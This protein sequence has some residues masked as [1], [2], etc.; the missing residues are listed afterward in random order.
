[1]GNVTDG[2]KSAFRDFVTD[3]VPASGANKPFKSEAR[4]LGAI[5]ESAL[6]TI[7]LGSVD[8]TKTTR[9]LLNADLAHAADSVGLVY[10]DS[11]D[12]NN[13][14]Y[15]KVG[16]TGSGSWTL[17]TVLH[18]AIGG[19]ATSQVAA[20]VDAQVDPLV[21]AAADSATA[22]ASS[23]TAAGGSAT[24]AAASEAAAAASAATVAGSR[25]ASL[26]SAVDAAKGEAALKALFSFEGT[27]TFSSGSNVATW[28]DT[29]P[30]ALVASLYSTLFSGANPRPVYASDGISF[31][32]E[33]GLTVSSG[34]IAQTINAAIFLDVD[35]TAQSRTSY[36][37][38]AALVAGGAARTQGD[39]GIVTGGPLTAFTPDPPFAID[40]N[41]ADT[42][43]KRGYYRRGWTGVNTSGG[44][45]NTTMTGFP[46]FSLKGA[47]PATQL[48]DLYVNRFGQLELN[49]YNGGAQNYQATTRGWPVFSG[50]HLVSIH[51][52]RST[53]WLYVD[54]R[55]AGAAWIGAE[56]CTTF[57]TT[58]FNGTSRQNNALTPVNGLAHKAR[59]RGAIENASFAEFQGVHD[60]LA[61]Y[62]DSPKLDNPLYYNIIC[63]L[64]Q[65][66]G[67]ASTDVSA[68]P[69][70]I[71][72]WNGT[73]IP[74]NTIGSGHA[75]ESAKISV[76]SL[77]GK[78][79]ATASGYAA[80]SH[81][82]PM[83]LITNSAG[84]KSTGQ[85]YYQPNG[86]GIEIGLFRYIL[87]DP[88]TPDA[89][90]GYAAACQ[91][92]APVEYLQTRSQPTIPYRSLRGTATTSMTFP[93]Q[94]FP[95]A[96]ASSNLDF[97]LAQIAWQ[98]DHARARGQIPR[99]VALIPDSA[100]IGN[101]V[102]GTTSW[103]TNT[104]NFYDAF[105][106]HCKRLTDQ[107]TD[108]MMLVQAHS[109]SSDGTQMQG[110]NNTPYA[111]QQCLDV[112]AAR[113]SRGIYYIG[114]SYHHSPKGHQPRIMYRAHGEETGVP[115]CAVFNRGVD[116]Q[117]LRVIAVINAS[118]SRK[119]VFNKSVAL[120]ETFGKAVTGWLRQNTYITGGILNPSLTVTG[121]ATVTTTNVANDTI[122]IPVSGTPTTGDAWSVG[123]L[124][125]IYTNIRHVTGLTGNF[126]SLDFA[127]TPDG[128][129]NIVFAESA[130]NNVLDEWA[131]PQN[132]LLTFV[133]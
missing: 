6:G 3:G 22:A 55:C 132:A 77:D 104:I 131:A 105:A 88:D 87:N 69:F 47:N 99:V 67:D 13:D 129:G 111:D 119:F 46:I 96:I 107:T 52:W 117:H 16:A 35:F 97:C 121:D 18:G 80:P 34:L 51:F 9:T 115:F 76:D 39:I 41:Q 75:L 95:P 100:A 64:N 106:V 84:T 42:N 10:A 57:T 60:A 20:Q 102:P 118:G 89:H 38:T 73:V 15:I 5:I 63:Q 128:S 86:E 24:A 74:S 23:A 110:I 59:V 78:V 83:S 27:K 32:V 14:L 12:A 25:A 7:Q 54:G 101:L 56:N 37:D 81:V 43:I 66:R 26:L 62:V 133:L 33:A 8:V 71:G 122:N 44:D 53:M 93:S 45:W 50:K 2:F 21:A 108:P 103:V 79:F 98:A 94:V 68:W 49:F 11:T 91:G 72:T 124:G 4:G 70:L 19:L 17:T 127:A 130:S 65:S 109:W 112:M 30:A 36:A 58:Y 114:A 123:G 29:S 116:Y 126:K 92:S 90:W 1:M 28:T 113:G 40:T 125:A 120:T 48:L 61:K 31:G 82:G 85:S